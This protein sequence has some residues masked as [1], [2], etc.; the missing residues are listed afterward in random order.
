[1]S[2]PYYF[3][4]LRY[5]G[6]KGKIAEFIKDIITL[7]RLQDGCYIEPYAGGAAVALELLLLDYVST[8]WIND[9][10]IS[11]H[12][13]WEC[14]INHTEELCGRILTVP[15]DMESWHQ[16]KAVQAEPLKAT[17]MELGFSTFFLN[18]CNR[19]G[20][21]S[22]GV[23]GGKNQTGQWK[24]DARFNRGELVKRIHQIARFKSRIK[25]SR[26][27][28]VQFLTNSSFVFPKK[29]LIY[30]DPPYYVKS[31][32]LYD[33]SYS[34]QDHAGVADV[35]ENLKGVKWV[36]SYDDEPEIRELYSKFRKIT[37]SLS[38]SVKER[39]KGR[40]AM[41]FSDDL[42]IPEVPER[43]PIQLIAS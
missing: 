16:Q 21:I 32:R 5:P 41:F 42:E 10:N 8:I 17:T 33:S 29:T 25:L 9:L 12:A 18:R 1:M 26:M 43:S 2:S 30:L 36:V 23:I 3:S 15:L 24:L 28:A 6:G 31:K 4:P 11:V 37:Y 7:N 35:V 14:V 39:Y 22:G 20:I 34:P 13:F 38:Y 19:S 27:D 40:E